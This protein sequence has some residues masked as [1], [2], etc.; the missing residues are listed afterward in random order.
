MC[1]YVFGYEL[2]VY[3]EYCVDKYGIWLWIWLNIKVFVVEFDDEYSLW[4]V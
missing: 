3:V 1:I 2:K 4:W